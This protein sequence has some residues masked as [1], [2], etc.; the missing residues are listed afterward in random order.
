MSKLD[1]NLEI[2]NALKES[3][4]SCVVTLMDAK[5]RKERNSAI[6]QAIEDGYTQ[7]EVGKYIGL[8]RLTVSKIIKSRYS[9]PKG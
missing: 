4:W 3:L 1:P 5:E 6:I 8:S 2:F 7:T 9:T